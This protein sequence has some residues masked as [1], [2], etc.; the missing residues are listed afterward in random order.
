MRSVLCST[1]LSLKLV[2]GMIAKCIYNIPDPEDDER[3]GA[4]T[5]LKRFGL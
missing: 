4:L 5:A 2:S 3:I 1:C